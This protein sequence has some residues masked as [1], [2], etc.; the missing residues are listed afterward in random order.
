MEAPE[1]HLHTLV[2]FL[3]AHYLLAR[4]INRR[5]LEISDLST[6]DL[7]GEGLTHTFR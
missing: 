7:P 3:I 1:A 5:N 2:N 4:S 6:L